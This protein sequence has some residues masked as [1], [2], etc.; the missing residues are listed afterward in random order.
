MSESISHVPQMP[1]DV[2]DLLERKSCA[3]HGK[4]FPM[5]FSYVYSTH[6]DW[7]MRVF[8]HDKHWVW[9]TQAFERCPASLEATPDRIRAYTS[10]LDD[11]L[12]RLDSRNSAR[13][14]LQEFRDTPP[15][16]TKQ[17]PVLMD[18]KFKF[19]RICSA[20][21]RNELRCVWFFG[22]SG[23][24]KT[25]GA[26]AVLRS[27]A[28]TGK[29]CVAYSCTELFDLFR[30]IAGNDADPGTLDSIAGH[31]VI[32]VDNLEDGR[33]TDAVRD[34]LRELLNRSKGVFLWTTVRDPRDSIPDQ[35]EPQ[36]ATRMMEGTSKNE[37][38]TMI[39]FSPAPKWRGISEK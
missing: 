34:N 11:M 18:L 22:P 4:Q 1:D 31:D 24:G 29:Q 8:F 9:M 39:D 36:L 15:L 25:H 35:F 33:I 38:L 17:D 10:R 28:Q 12:A 20:I 21:I 2:R 3:C 7:H 16:H 32:L 23:H 30:R 5:N 13:F 6:R 26:A 27:L 37:K 19:N 14:T